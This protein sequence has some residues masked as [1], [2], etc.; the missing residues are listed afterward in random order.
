MTYDKYKT[1]LEFVTKVG[2]EGDQ[3]RSYKSNLFKLDSP[4]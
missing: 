4:S 1:L 2:P 3:K